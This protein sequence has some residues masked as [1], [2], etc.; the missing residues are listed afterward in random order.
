MMF[1]NLLTIPIIFT[2]MATALP[3][4]TATIV[5]KWECTSLTA[6]ENGKE[7]GTVR[8]N[9]G[10]VVYTYRGDKTWQ[11]DSNLGKGKAGMKGTFELRDDDLILTKS[12]GKVYKDFHLALKD[13]GKT[14][15]MKDE[16]SLVT[17]SKID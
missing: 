5:G 12:D 13:D 8:F 2:I 10:N 15:V 14:L 11:L 17:A 3:I 1:K 16:G 6:L 7:S 9:P 4:S